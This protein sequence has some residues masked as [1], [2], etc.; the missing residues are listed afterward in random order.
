MIR[1]NNMTAYDK[2]SA[3]NMLAEIGFD[4]FDID[5]MTTYLSAD[6]VEELEKERSGDNYELIA[7]GYYMC[8]VNAINMIEEFLEATR[9]TKAREKLEEIKNA[10]E[11]Y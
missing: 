11:N 4:R 5:E 8:I 7:D 3:I 1:M 2:D 10:L 6:I 9:I